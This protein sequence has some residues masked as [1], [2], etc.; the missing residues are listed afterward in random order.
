MPTMDEGDLIVQLEKLP[1]INLE[2]SLAIDQRVQRAIMDEVPE[3][4]GVVA[5]TG[6]DELGLDPMGLNQTDSFLVLAPPR[7]GASPPRTS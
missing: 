6:S 2:E 7:T 1:S 4:R 3:V 5:R